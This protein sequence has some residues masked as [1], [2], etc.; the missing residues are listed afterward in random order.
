MRPELPE[1]DDTT[2]TTVRAAARALTAQQG[3]GI[4]KARLVALA[5]LPGRAVT[6]VAGDPPVA[7]LH[8]RP[9]AEPEVFSSLT[10]RERQVA[11][12]LGDGLSNAEIAARLVVSVPTVKDHVHRILRKTG[13]GSRAAVASALHR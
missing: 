6:V 11:R 4:R 2:V 3:R 7:V 1:V 5:E 10:P 12:L 8:A 13:L 9:P